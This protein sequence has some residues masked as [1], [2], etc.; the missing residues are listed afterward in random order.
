MRSNSSS[1]GLK[2]VLGGRRRVRGRLLWSRF[3]LWILVL[4]LGGRG[5]ESRSRSETFINMEG[6]Y[7]SRVLME[8]IEGLLWICLHCDDT[9]ILN[10]LRAVLILIGG[11]VVWSSSSVLRK[12]VFRARWGY[13]TIIA[14]VVD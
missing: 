7:A 13:C 10:T 2:M 9:M 14:V 5:S 8:W 12:D 6:S 1:S 3:G 4:S 11:L